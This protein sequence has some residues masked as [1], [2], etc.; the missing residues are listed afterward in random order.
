MTIGNIE[1]GVE[2]NRFQVADPNLEGVEVK[3]LVTGNTVVRLSNVE[4]VVIDEH[5]IEL[6]AYDGFNSASDLVQDELSSSSVSVFRLRNLHSGRFLFSS[7]AGEIDVLTGQQAWVNEGFS[8][9]SPRGASSAQVYRFY[10]PDENRHFYTANQYE[11][12]LLWHGDDRFVF[13]GASFRV[14]SPSLAPEGAT[15]V[16]RYFSSSQGICI[17]QAPMSR[18]F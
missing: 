1:T 13:E 12:D 6:Q 15:P 18:K 9:A 10:I 4:K 16:F 11:R 7:N 17:H 5:V 8:Y 2:S 14:P 3:D